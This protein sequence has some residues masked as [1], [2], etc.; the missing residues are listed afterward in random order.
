MTPLTEEHLQLYSP[1]DG[2]FGPLVYAERKT[3]YLGCRELAHIPVFPELG[4]GRGT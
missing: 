3:R 1:V 4:G 2:T